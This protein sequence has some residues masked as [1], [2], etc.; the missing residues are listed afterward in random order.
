[1]RELVDIWRGPRMK[2]TTAIDDTSTAAVL[3]CLDVAVILIDVDAVVDNL[4]EQSE[5]ILGI[6]RTEIMG[7]QFLVVEEVNTHI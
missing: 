1:M 2:S 4:N 5:P 6:D 7:R 3:K